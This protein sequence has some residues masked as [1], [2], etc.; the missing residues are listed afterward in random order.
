MKRVLALLSCVSLL[1]LQA[2]HEDPYLTVSPESLSF[3]QEG[4]S[5]T[6]QVSANYAWTASVSG[7]GF[8]VSPASGEGDA[9][10]TVTASAASARSEEH[11]SELQSRT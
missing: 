8:S 2:C 11:T 10:L 6:V 9:T 4:G 3:T 1:L 5:Q 7:S